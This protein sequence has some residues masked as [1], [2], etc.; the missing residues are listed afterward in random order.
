MPEEENARFP[1]LPSA[2][3][4]YG[5]ML[6]D[7]NRRWPDWR[8]APVETLRSVAADWEALREGN[9][10]VVRLLSEAEIEWSTRAY[11]VWYQ[12]RLTPET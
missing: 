3:Q 8:K 10:A 7:V 11:D 1:S 9:G 4:A 5:V 12:G 6:A 2:A